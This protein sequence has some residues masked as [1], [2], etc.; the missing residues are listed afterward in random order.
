MSSAATMPRAVICSRH[1][2]TRSAARCCRGLRLHVRRGGAGGRL[3][4]LVPARRRRAALL[5]HGGGG[6][7]GDR[8]LELRGGGGCCSVEA[9]P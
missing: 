7:P 2:G 3:L 8:Q 4:D 6:G 5:L 9:Q 1:G